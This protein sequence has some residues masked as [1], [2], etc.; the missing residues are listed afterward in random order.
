MVNYVLIA[1]A[2][3]SCAM[4][5]I[6]KINCVKQYDKAYEK[7]YSAAL[8]VFS[9]PDNYLNL[10]DAH[11][12]CS[13]EWIVVKKCTEENVFPYVIIGFTII[14]MGLLKIYLER[15]LRVEPRH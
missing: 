9:D 2:G 15:R 14:S 13:K 3:W 10:Q 4:T 8:E 5:W 11:D 7:C 6:Q 1:G 12:L